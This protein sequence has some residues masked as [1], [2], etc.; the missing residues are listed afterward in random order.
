MKN[1]GSVVSSVKP[2]EDALYGLNSQ[3]VIENHGVEPDG[4]RAPR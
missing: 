3:W 2:T 1:Q 4:S